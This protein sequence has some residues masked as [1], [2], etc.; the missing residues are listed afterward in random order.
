MKRRSV[1]C[2]II[3][4]SM[5][6][7][8]AAFAQLAP[9]Q[10]KEQGKAGM[11]QQRQRMTPEEMAKRDEERINNR[12]AELTQKLNLTPQQQ[13]QV[14]DILTKTSAQIREMMQQVREKVGELFKQDRE[15]IKALLTEDQKANMGKELEGPGQEGPQPP[16]P[17]EGGQ[18]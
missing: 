11:M 3:A 6:A 15:S 5:L 17:P 2:G 18:K 13:A 4:F 1:V 8:P 10:G 12:V 14:K 16:P 7:I 9:Q